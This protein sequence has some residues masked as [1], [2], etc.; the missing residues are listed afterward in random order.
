M[1]NEVKKYEVDDVAE[2]NLYRDLFPYSAPPAIRFDGEYETPSLPKDIWITDTTFRDGQQARPPYTTEQILD[3]FELLHNL[4]GESGVIRASEF[5]LY[6]E[7]DREAVSKC[8][9]KGWRYP[10]VTGWIRA[11]KNDF[12]L[13]KQMGLKETGILTSV[14][15]Y[16]VFL[17]LRLG[18][19]KALE[20]YLEIVNFALEEGIRIRCHFEDV[21]RADIFGFCIPFAQKLMELSSQSGIP[22]KIRLCDT[23]GYGIPFPGVALPRSVP[24]LVRAFRE[25][26]GVPAECLEWHGHNDFHMVLVNTVAAWVY[27]CSGANSSLLGYGERTG[28]APLEGLVFEY[29]GLKP[30]PEGLDTRQITKIADYFRDRVGA[31]IPTNYPFVGSAFNMTRAGIHA[32]GLLKNEEIYNIFDTRKLL[33]RPIQV[34]ITDKS[35]V[36]GVAHWVDTHLAKEGLKVDKRHPGIVRIFQSIMELYGQGRTTSISDAEMLA[37]TREHLP[38]YFQD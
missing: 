6:S 34:G 20:K 5:F 4:D 18:R 24:K 28:N 21:T 35:G 33:D 11:V 13:V 38:E 23:M 26:A 32:D 25:E 8:L 10:E 30:A 27:G 15:D 14:S 2:A 7:K 19:K 3:L 12:Q 1:M 36:A 22:I 17:K 31:P 37:L 29:L 9:E 16:H